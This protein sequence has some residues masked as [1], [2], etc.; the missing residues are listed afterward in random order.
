MDVLRNAFKLGLVVALAIVLVATAFV[1]GYE[2]GNETGGKSGS[3]VEEIAA[4]PVDLVEQ[5]TATAIPATAEPE[6]TP[7]PEDTPAPEQPS[8]PPDTASPTPEPTREAALSDEEAL[9]VLSEVWG[10]I[11]AEF[12]GDLPTPDE[13]IYGAIRGMLATLDDQYTSFL[14]PSIAEI[15][16]TDASGAFEGIGALVNVGEDG[17]LEIVRPFQGSPA[18]EAG[19]LPGDKVLAVDGQSIVGYGIWEAITLIRGPEGSEVVLTIQREEGEPFAATVLRARIDIPI[20]ESEMLEADIGYVSLFE[21]TSQATSQLEQMIEE[22]LDQGA[23]ALIFDLRGNPGGFLD[24][25]VQVSDLFLDEGV[26][27]I[28]RISD[29]QEREFT[30]RD[31]GLAQDIPLVVL[32]N[33][34]SASASEIVAGAIQDRGRG[35]LIGETTFGKGSVQL[36]HTLSDGSELRVT[37]ARWFTPNDRAIHGEGLAPDIEVLL[38]LEDLE[39]ERDPQLERAIEYLQQQAGQ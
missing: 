10:L 39:A 9:Q 2:A 19:L 32:V 34:G 33:G 8:S 1:I 11:D 28:E 23:T 26:V 14:E 37:I 4:P 22:L 38:T 13:R 5:P 7:P 20:V 27:L 25:A 29:G 21:F 30:S 17:I 15:E 31:Q 12:Y 6:D 16:R 24:Q 18:E 3:V 36:P 35:V